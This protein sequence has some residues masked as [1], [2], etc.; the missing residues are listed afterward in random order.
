MVVLLAIVAAVIAFSA[1]M[2]VALGRAAAGADREMEIDRERELARLHRRS[3]LTVLP[4]GY[5]GWSRAH[6]TISRE[7]STT[8]P[9]SS[10]SVGTQRFPVSS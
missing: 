5:A 8:V 10:T 9:S 6:A 3:R 1:V 4:G 7:P 2:A